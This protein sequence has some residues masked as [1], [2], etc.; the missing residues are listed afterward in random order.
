MPP[1]HR[2]TTTMTSSTPRMSCT[3]PS[4]GPHKCSQQRR[5][6]ARGGATQPAQPAPGDGADTTTNTT[7]GGTNQ[8]MSQPGARSS[9]SVLCTTAHQYAHRVPQACKWSGAVQQEV[10]GGGGRGGWHSRQGRGWR[11]ED[12]CGHPL[13]SSLSCKMP[14]RSSRIRYAWRGHVWAGR[15]TQLGPQ[16]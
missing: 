9:F 10:P 12:T 15:T 14:P 4:R 11:G 13:T 16:R 1:Y 6:Q 7:A 5:K 2:D 8:Q 3:G